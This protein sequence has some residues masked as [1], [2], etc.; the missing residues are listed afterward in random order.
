MTKARAAVPLPARKTNDRAS[1]TPYVHP[2]VMNRSISFRLLPICLVAVALQPAHANE[3]APK[4]RFRD[5]ATHETLSRVL[6]AENNRDPLSKITPSDTQDPSKHAQ[7]TDIL[8][9]SDIIS[10][11][12]LTTLVP[13]R[14]ILALP[15]SM[16]SRVGNHPPGHR[17]VHWREFLAAN[18]GW[19]STIEVTRAQAEGRTKLADESQERISNASHMIVATLLGGPISVLPETPQPPSTKTQPE[20]Q[21]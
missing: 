3:P 19:I 14:A 7:P 2:P 20:T 11:N 6:Q 18:R 1:S 17:L 5:S 4:P 8:E 15:E 21:P 10:F 13:K 12:G 9:R 16:T